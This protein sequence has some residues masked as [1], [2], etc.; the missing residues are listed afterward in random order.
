MTSDKSS[1]HLAIFTLALAGTL[2]A[3]VE[4]SLNGVSPASDRHVSRQVAP[5]LSIAVEGDAP[6][7]TAQI[8][9]SSVT[10][11]VMTR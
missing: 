9:D 3:W 2:L 4:M 11:D 5:G 10:T 1:L 7:M 6:L 8:N